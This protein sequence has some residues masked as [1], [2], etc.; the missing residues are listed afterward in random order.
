MTSQEQ[1]LKALHGCGS[2]PS[3]CGACGAARAD[4]G[5]CWRAARAVL[6][7]FHQHP[8][9]AGKGFWAVLVGLFAQSFRS[10][11]HRA[12]QSF[13]LVPHRGRQAFRSHSA[14]RFSATVA[15][16]PG[17]SAAASG[18]ARMMPRD[19]VAALHTLLACTRAPATILWPGVR[20]GARWLL[21]GWLAPHRR[22]GAGKAIGPHGPC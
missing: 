17:A 20:R 22:P 2:P 8:K 16:G 1:S 11:P 7:F 5:G 3:N 15:A 18:V 13:R 14:S 21:A 6:L 9:K 19:P 12:R 10:A 4:R